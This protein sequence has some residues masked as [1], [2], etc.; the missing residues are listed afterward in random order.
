MRFCAAIKNKESEVDQGK[1]I[2]SVY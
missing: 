2:I 1:S